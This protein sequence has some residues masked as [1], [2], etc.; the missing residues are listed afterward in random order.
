MNKLFVLNVLMTI[1]FSSCF[2]NSNGNS[3]GPNE[4]KSLVVKEN[5][6][7]AD[8][9]SNEK[10]IKKIQKKEENPFSLKNGQTGCKLEESL[11]YE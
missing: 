5:K 11:G 10:I 6:K 8:C 3:K 9:D 7:K 1:L 4:A 2:R